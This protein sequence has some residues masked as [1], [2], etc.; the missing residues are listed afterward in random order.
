M[1][2]LTGASGNIGKRM[3]QRFLREGIDFIG[4][5]HVNNAELPEYV[6]KTIDI[7]DSALA[8]LIEKNGIDSI[9]HL[10]FCTKPK[11]DP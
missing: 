2:L 6:F 7:R 8:D 10:A 4:I 1:I 9:I 5:D 11:I 3:A